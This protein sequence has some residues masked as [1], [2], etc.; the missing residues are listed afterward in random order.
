MN[1]YHKMSTYLFRKSRD[2]FLPREF[3]I[4]D[5]LDEFE[6]FSWKGVVCTSLFSKLS[7]LI[8]SRILEVS[9]KSK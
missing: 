8:L 5:N 7:L 2:M 1:I 6:I 9:V 4:C 3:I